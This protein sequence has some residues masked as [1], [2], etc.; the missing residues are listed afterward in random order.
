[1]VRKSVLIL[2]GSKENLLSKLPIPAVLE[3]SKSPSKSEGCSYHENEYIDNIMNALCTEKMVNRAFPGF[4]YEGSRS[5][6]LAYHML[7]ATWH[8]F[9]PIFAEVATKMQFDAWRRDEAIETLFMS[10]DGLVG[11][12]LIS[13]AIDNESIMDSL[14]QEFAK[15]RYLHSH[16]RDEKAS[17]N[18]A[19][20]KFIESQNWIENVRKLSVSDKEQASNQLRFIL[21]STKAQ[22]EFNY[23]QDR[24]KDL[25]TRMQSDIVRLEFS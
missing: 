8:L 18:I 24:V 7:E 11:G 5:Y 15:I 16:Y 20:G 12:I 4:E 10:L 19:T 14:M 2:K 17:H 22:I 21:D 25:Q 9:L 3:E 23:E 13:V 6:R 1:M